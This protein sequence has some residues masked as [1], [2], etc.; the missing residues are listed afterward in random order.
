M[1]LKVGD[2]DVC[3]VV[4][5]DGD[6]LQD[7]SMLRVVDLLGLR[8]LVGRSPPT[9]PSRPASS[10]VRLG[11]SSACP[12]PASVAAPGGAANGNQAHQG[13]ERPRTPPGSVRPNGRGGG[14]GCPGHGGGAQRRR[15]PRNEEAA[16][17]G[18]LDG[19]RGRRGSVLLRAV[20][21][22]GPGP[23][24]ARGRPEGVPPPF[25]GLTL[26]ERDD[27][28]PPAFSEEERRALCGTCGT[29]VVSWDAHRIGALHLERT[30]RNQRAARAAAAG[31]AGLRW[32]APSGLTAGLEEAAVRVL[33]ATR[34]DLLTAVARGLVSGEPLE[35]AAN[36]GLAGGRPALVAPPIGAPDP[37]PGAC[38]YTAGR[39]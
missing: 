12:G 29:L 24:R 19:G 27:E 34:P 26:A 18:H 15:P 28:P 4:V 39:L 10:G 21:L 1:E 2:F 36:Q 35:C 33:M 17:R 25:R 22:E 30:A 20:A 31:A 3:G 9:G 23:A 8:Q 5:A 38:W 7:I 14:Q 11:D 13:G 6:D 32:S 37:A 16:E